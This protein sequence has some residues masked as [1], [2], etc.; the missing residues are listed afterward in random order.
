MKVSIL[1][2]RQAEDLVLDGQLAVVSITD[3]QRPNVNLRIASQQ[4]VLKRVSFNDWAWSEEM[5][6]QEATD[7][8]HD[9]CRWIEKH[10]HY[11]HFVIH[12]WAGISRSAAVALYL[13]EMYGADVQGGFK[14]KSPNIHVL[15]IMRYYK[16]YTMD[17]KENL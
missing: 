4:V 8:L 16:R 12:C 7:Q 17:K 6:R 2:Q 15:N 14:F 13:A 10:K 1:S 3:I 9:L 5:I 11:P